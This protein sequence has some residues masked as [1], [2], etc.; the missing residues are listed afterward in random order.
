[1]GENRIPPAFNGPG[2]VDLQVNG[3][4]GFDF[5]SRHEGWTA[6]D[7]H[8]VR[9]TMRRRGVVAALPTFITDDAA[10][11]L[12]RAVTYARLVE[13]D[14][15]LAEAF[16]KIHV[17]GPFIAR[18]DGPRGAHPTTYCRNPVDL[19]D[20]LERLYDASD[21]RIGVLT[22]APELPGAL[23]LIA[24]AAD[25]DICVAIGHTNAAPEI[26]RAAT[27]AGA[28][29]ST[30]LGNATHL[31]LPRS[32]NYVQA[33]L[34]E[35]HLWA[36]FIADGHHIPWY[37]LKNF[38]RAKPHGRSVLV[39]DAMAAAD[40]GPGRYR[41]GEADVVV[42][43]D[44][45][46]SAPRAENLAGS[47]LT[48]DRAVINVATHC[49]VPFSEAWKMASERPARLAGIAVPREVRVRISPD[50]FQEA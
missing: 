22:L 8:R 19:P 38:I 32:A 2:L 27:E 20:F 21:G 46:V 9:I 13:G 49:G 25:Q 24:R 43:D 45:R 23:D 15:L 4:G 17:E 14:A 35:D 16:P 33:Q 30:H 29:M 28:A 50:G 44:L 18:E 31:T 42:S 41:L 7:F 1:M 37:A 48:L 34:A 6:D 39:T 40:V 10:R 12:S 11:M 5:N 47:A 3:Y 36:S 26:I